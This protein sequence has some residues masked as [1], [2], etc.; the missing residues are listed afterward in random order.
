MPHFKLK[1][2]S[3]HLEASDLGGK[4]VTVKIAKVAGWAPTA[5]DAKGDNKPKGLFTIEPYPGIDKTTWVYP[6]T[7]ARCMAAMFGDDDDGWVGRR[8]TIRAEKVEAFGEMVDAIRPI[9]SPDIEKAVTFSVPK[10]RGKVKVT[11][12]KM[13]PR[14][15]QSDP[16]QP[17]QG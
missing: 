1:F 5:T 14:A 11:M 9:G 15:K 10:G 12:R 4:L 13:E 8:V 6:V 3:E 2:P 7:V 17:A 16:D